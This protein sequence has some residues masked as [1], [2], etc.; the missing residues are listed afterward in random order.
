MAA[1]RTG[2]IWASLG[3]LDFNLYYVIG[4]SNA[5]INECDV[6]KFVFLKDNY[7]S[8]WEGYI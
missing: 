8:Q 4:N 6:N 3:N 1:S 2:K 7:S 5:F